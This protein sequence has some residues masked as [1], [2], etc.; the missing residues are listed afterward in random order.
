M[1]KCHVACTPFRPPSGV[2]PEGK[3]S[4]REKS[5]S[6]GP[7]RHEGEAERGPKDRERRDRDA[8]AKEGED[9]E[10]VRTEAG[11]RRRTPPPPILASASLSSFSPSGRCKR[12]AGSH[13][14][15]WVPS[16]IGQLVAIGVHGYC[17]ERGRPLMIFGEMVVMV[18]ASASVFAGCGGRGSGG[19]GRLGRGAGRSGLLLPV[20][21]GV[22][23]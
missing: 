17:G 16:A 1:A 4:L 11:R 12:T 15:S 7:A 23:L 21:Q 8:S 5:V 9:A 19:V 14:S 6:V 22:G 20:A 10:W 13:R 3:S 18:L 2:V